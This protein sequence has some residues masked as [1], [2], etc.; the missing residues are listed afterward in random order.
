MCCCQSCT[1]C[2][3]CERAVTKERPSKLKLKREIN[4]VKGVS[5]VDHC[6]FAQNV[7]SAPNV[8]HVKPVGG[9]LQDFWQKWS[10]LGANP[11]VVSILKDRYILPFKIRPPLVRAVDNQ[12]ICKPHQE[13]LPE[14]GFAC[15]DHQ[16]SGREG[17]GSDL[18]SFLQQDI[19]CPQTK[20]EMAA[21]LGPQCS[22][23]IFERKNIQNG[24]P[25]DNSNL[26]IT[27]GMGDIA[28]FQRRLFPHS[29]TLLVQEIPPVSLPKPDILVL[30]SS[31]LPLNSSYGV[32][33]CGQR[34]QV[35]GSI[36]GY[37]DPPVPRRLVDS[38]PHQRI[39]PPGHPVP[40]RPLPGVG[41]GSESPK[42]GVGTQ[43]GV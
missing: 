3:K 19:H 29:S 10:L 43:A 39:L 17:K 42:I 26:L 28:G 13:L 36:S 2:L 11:R 32:H 23:Q 4:F 18:S 24:D 33:L 14:G 40:P 9:C 30:D 37:K 15:T 41:L 27:R 38:S 31:L 34:G 21:N 5:I 35:N 6:V 25:R 1:F 8:A 12:W 16:E 20:S 7:P 22:K